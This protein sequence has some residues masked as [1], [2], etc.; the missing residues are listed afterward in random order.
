MS[1]GRGE[2][3]ENLARPFQR[4]AIDTGP[5]GL[6]LIGE[7][8][9]GTSSLRDLVN[10]SHA[11]HRHLHVAWRRMSSMP[12]HWYC[13]FAGLDCPAFVKRCSDRIR[14]GPAPTATNGHNQHLADSRNR[15]RSLDDGLH[16]AEDPG[17][18]AH[19][20]P[21]RLR[22][23]AGSA[24]AHACGD[25]RSAHVEDRRAGFDWRFSIALLEVSGTVV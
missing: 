12:D 16:S 8:H 22:P 10:D 5:G 18:A 19:L 25:P 20:R 21:S 9:E 17:C 6:G 14:C 15:I 13:Y 1:L 2:N 11:S 24:A 4:A 7:L 3:K 23:C